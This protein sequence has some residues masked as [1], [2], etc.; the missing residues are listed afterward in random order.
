MV[1]SGKNMRRM[2]S[3]MRRKMALCLVLAALLMGSAARGESTVGKPGYV[4]FEPFEFQL[5]LPM[6]WQVDTLDVSEIEDGYA[7]RR[8]CS[9]DGENL[10]LVECF[11]NEAYSLSEA[12]LD[13]QADESYANISRIS[14]GEREFVLY[15]Y[16]G[17]NAMGAITKVQNGRCM[18]YIE[19]YPADT[20]VMVE[21]TPQIL[22]S[23]EG[24]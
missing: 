8:A 24:L 3:G 7:W 14:V 19:F 6:D 1:Y 12:Y 22:A 13:Y 16:A 9:G 20:P 2:D 17:T 23:L 21:L 4:V 10:M 11:V 18:V 5:W 15:E